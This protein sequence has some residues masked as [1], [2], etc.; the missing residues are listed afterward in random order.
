[1]LCCVVLGVESGGCVALYPPEH[2]VGVWWEE[3]SEGV[4]GGRRTEW[5]L[6][7]DCLPVVRI[8]WR[9]CTLVFESTILLVPL[10]DEWLL[11][12]VV[13]AWFTPVLEFE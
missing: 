10:R 8:G 3:G 5:C 1:M 9:R 13:L 11:F 2:S 4:F 6:I 12:N 7:E